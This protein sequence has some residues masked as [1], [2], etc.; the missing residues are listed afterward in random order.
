M[1]LK[2]A[3]A[4]GRE[5]LANLNTWSE[6]VTR[7]R[8][9]TSAMH[10]ML[11]TL[12][13]IP[14]VLSHRALRW[15]VSINKSPRHQNAYLPCATL[16]TEMDICVSIMHWELCDRCIEGLVDL[17]YWTDAMLC[18]RLPGNP[19]RSGAMLYVNQ[20]EILD[21]QYCNYSSTRSRNDS[22]RLGV[23]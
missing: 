8:G 14:D 15:C 2:T 23:D 4:S 9:V 10:V 5:L 16:R 3:S 11:P 19:Q 7:L 17:A 13:Y 1:K 22:L 20:F 18:E 21:R 6:K 12:C